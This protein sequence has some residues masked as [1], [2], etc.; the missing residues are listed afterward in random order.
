VTTYPR[1][2]TKKKREGK[3]LGREKGIVKEGNVRPH[4]TSGYRKKKREGGLPRK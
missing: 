4:E 1:G 3:S 2:R